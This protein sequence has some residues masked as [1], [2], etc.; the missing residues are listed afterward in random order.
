[1]D[2]EEGK[3]SPPMCVPNYP[4]WPLQDQ[5]DSPGRALG[6][7][8]LSPCST[9]LEY[10]AN[11]CL[12]HPLSALRDHKVR[13]LHHKHSVR[14]C[15]GGSGGGQLAAECGDLSKSMSR[16]GETRH[17]TAQGLAFVQSPAQEKKKS[18]KTFSWDQ[19]YC[20]TYPPSAVLSPNGLR[21]ACLRAIPQDG[22]VT[23]A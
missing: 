12:S 5:V 17:Y 18:L 7:L 10:R 16:S 2:W 14:G 23:S 19:V 6:P 1:M 22:I 15:N 8:S 11:G 13:K 9:R 20:S 21:L 3:D 4:T